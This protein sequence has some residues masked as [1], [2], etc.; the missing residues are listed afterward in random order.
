MTDRISRRTGGRQEGRFRRSDV[1]ECFG[2]R[3]EP[4]EERRM[5]AMLYV[6][7]DWVGE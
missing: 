5:L 6:S 1:A 4:L 2:L 3:F 7:R